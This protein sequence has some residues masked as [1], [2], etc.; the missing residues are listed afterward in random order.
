MSRFILTLDAVLAVRV[1]QRAAAVR[2]AVGRG[3]GRRVD[4]DP[5]FAVGWGTLDDASVGR[6]LR[7]LSVGARARLAVLN[8]RAT[9][10]HGVCGIVGAANGGGSARRGLGRSNGRHDWRSAATTRRS[11]AQTLVNVLDQCAGVRALTQKLDPHGLA[12]LLV[13]NR[14]VFAIHAVE[15]LGDID[16]TVLATLA[17]G[18]GVGLE[19]EGALGTVAHVVLEAVDNQLFVVVEVSHHDWWLDDLD[20]A[21]HSAGAAYSEE[22]P[23]DAATRGI[24]WIGA[25]E[26]IERGGVGAFGRHG[27]GL[28]MCHARDSG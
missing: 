1:V 7:G 3:M 25:R 9:R 26:G 2:A 24:A 11:Q 16:G 4:D 6:G 19:G 28:S 8:H 15:I 13:H 18:I 23:S 17:E 14:E 5:G 12:V 21:R 10:A 22:P 20:G 27:D